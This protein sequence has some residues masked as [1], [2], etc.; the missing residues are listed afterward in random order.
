MENSRPCSVFPY[1]KL[2][3]RR[4]SDSAGAAEN[5]ASMHNDF[6]VPEMEHSPI[7][8]IIKLNI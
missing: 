7:T 3:L 5:S 8:I 2:I 6:L 1:R 4:S